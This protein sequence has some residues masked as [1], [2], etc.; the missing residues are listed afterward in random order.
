MSKAQDPRWVCSQSTDKQLLAAL[1]RRD[2]PTAAYLLG[3]LEEPFFSSSRWFL[4]HT[5]GALCGLVLL[6]EGLSTPCFL[7]YGAPDAI[8][9]I[10]K[11]FAPLWP[12]HAYAKLPDALLP[13]FQ[14]GFE[15]SEHTAMWCMSWKPSQTQAPERQEGGSEV[16]LLTPDDDVEAILS[17]Y[18]THYP[19]HYFEP[20][21]LTSGVY[22]GGF[23]EGELVSV[24]GTHVY[25]PGQHIACLGNIVTHTAHRGKG[26]ARATI[27]G[28]LQELQL[29]GIQDVILHVKEDNQAAI[30]CYRHLG[31][32]FHS[33]LF[34]LV[35]E[36]KTAY[37]A[38]TDTKTNV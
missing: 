34:D 38:K 6:Y 14:K 22:V 11:A 29:R 32:A 18:E 27:G 4:A 16:R 17:L 20:S 26:L 23:L 13:R 21:Q 30:A 9:E 35:I 36:P 25:A 12:S 33:T 28:L 24:A 8:E 3:D 10:V 31:F 37:T 15:T 2:V 19:G 7:A 1:L 5:R